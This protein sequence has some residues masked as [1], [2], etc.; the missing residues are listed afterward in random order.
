MI[1]TGPNMGGKSSYIKQVRIFN[2]KLV[3]VLSFLKELSVKR[4][5]AKYD[6]LEETEIIVS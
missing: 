2:S 3:I 4:N 1:I 6:W 5:K